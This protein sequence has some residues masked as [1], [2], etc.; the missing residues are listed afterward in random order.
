MTCKRMKSVKS[1]MPARPIRPSLLA[2][3]CDLSAVTGE[4]FLALSIVDLMQS[5]FSVSIYSDLIMQGLGQHGLLRDRLLPLYV[6]IVCIAQR[7]AGRRV[8]LLNYV[9]IWNF[10]NS[11][12]TRCGVRLAP[13]TGSALVVP[14]RARRCDRLLRLHLQKLLIGATCF[15]LSRRFVLWCATPSV[16]Q[17]LKTAGF[18]Q[19]YF[20]FPFLSRIHARVPQPV[21]FDVF[22]YSGTHTIKNHE[23]VCRWLHYT[24]STD[25]KVCYV[26][27]NL[28]EKYSQVQ[29]FEQ[30]PE[31]AFNSMLAR[32]ALYVSFS[33]EDAGI[34]GFKAL[35]FGVPVLCPTS[36]GLAYALEYSDTYCFTDP[37]DSPDILQRVECLLPEARDRNRSSNAC[38]SVFYQ[39]QEQSTAAAAAWLASL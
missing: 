4:G 9:P 19:L 16:Y 2:I 32:S 17:T 26:G 22:I 29:A 6:F 3:G 11:F 5:R 31:D 21:I 28:P 37:F 39:L 27:P 13:V 1:Q 35:A 20:G 24:A 14:A 30:L 33:F 36:S 18:P 7:L 10:L 34:T 8:V 38:H 12:L 25:L 15:L 23:A